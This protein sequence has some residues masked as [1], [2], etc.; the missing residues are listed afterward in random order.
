MK[1]V[2]VTQMYAAGTMGNDRPL[3][4]ILLRNIGIRRK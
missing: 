3:N 1:G 2:K 4:G